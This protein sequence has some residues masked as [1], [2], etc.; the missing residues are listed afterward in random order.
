MLPE[1]QGYWIGFVG[2]LFGVGG[3]V[4]VAIAGF[5]NTSRTAEQALEARHEDRLWTRKADAYQDAMA[6]ALQRAYCREKVVKTKAD[7]R[8]IP[9][10]EP[11]AEDPMGKEWFD[12]QGRLRI[13]GRPEVLTAF[14]VSMKATDAL[15]PGH[16]RTVR[17]TE[18]FMNLLHAAMA[19]DDALMHAIRCDL[20]T[21]DRSPPLQMRRGPA[22]KGYET[23]GGPEPDEEGTD[24]MGG[25]DAGPDSVR[26]TGESDQIQ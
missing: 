22:G 6:E 25:P 17:V 21:D 5:K 16:G 19:K 4:A 24:L 23:M 11:A 15:N 26:Q 7:D 13:Y 18:Q 10:K 2:V 20:G 12:M 14:E 1:V 9:A 3:T 8:E